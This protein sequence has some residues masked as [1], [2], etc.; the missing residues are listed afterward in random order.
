MAKTPEQKAAEKAEKD[1]KKAAAKAAKE[2]AG[3]SESEDS[4]VDA[5]D[6]DSEEPES[7]ESDDAGADDVGADDDHVHVFI[8][9]HFS[10]PVDGKRVVGTKDKVVFKMPRK[11]YE[12][13]E[14]KL[15]LAKP[16]KK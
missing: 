4:D 2:A 7:D 13:N 14:H 9:E 16:K 3:G 8:R 5:D 1:K 11:E 15:E 6:L 12:A 10:H